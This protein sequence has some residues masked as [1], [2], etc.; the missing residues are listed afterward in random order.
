VGIVHF[1][2]RGAMDIRGLGYERVRALL[3]ATLI[4]DV[5]DLYDRKKLGL[6]HLLTLE[7]FAEKSAAQ[8]LA[9]IDASK[10]QP[11]STLLFALGIR[12]VGSTVAKLV[13]RHFGKMD[14][15]QAA[16]AEEIGAIRGLGPIIAEAV[17]GFFA[18]KRNAKLIERLA[19]LGV[20]MSE[21][22]AAAA[23][24]PLSGQTYVITGTLPS[25]SRQEATRLI[26]SAGGNV[27]DGVSKRTTA[28]V[29]GADAG[30][31]LEK[32]RTLGTPVI[33]EAEL[34]RRAHRKP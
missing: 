29:V 2:A 25:L 28:V 20:T 9:A 21:P 4:A 6:P 7:G 5:A 31:K 33:D 12:H 13:A 3:D 8:L 26:E 30:S 34:L 10:R 27:A 17:A 14:R 22:S 24:G 23:D 11:L 16:T 15:L 1:A 32:A 19:K 18:E